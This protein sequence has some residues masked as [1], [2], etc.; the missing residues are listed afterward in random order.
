M[1]MPEQ[2]KLFKAMLKE[3]HKKV[4]WGNLQVE[5]V[6]EWFFLQGVIAGGD[7]VMKRLEEAEVIDSE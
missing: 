6:A 5:G 7:D 4:G 2:K 3:F 1:K